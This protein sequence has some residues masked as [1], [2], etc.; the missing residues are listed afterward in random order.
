MLGNRGEGTLRLGLVK[1]PALDSCAEEDGDRRLANNA[2]SKITAAIKFLKFALKV[3]ARETAGLFVFI[4]LKPHFRETLC[5][6]C[7]FSR[8][9]IKPR[10]NGSIRMIVDAKIR[11]SLR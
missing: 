6:R 4:K 7:S 3:L 2:V 8:G 5:D 11:S 9:S 10:D 1:A